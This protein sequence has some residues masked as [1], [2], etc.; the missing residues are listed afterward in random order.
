MASVIGTSRTAFPGTTAADLRAALEGRATRG[1]GPS[2]QP[3][4]ALRYALRVPE[5]R[6][7]DAERKLREAER[8]DRA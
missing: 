4:R 5:I 2:I 1:W 8:S 3:L 6:R 7:R